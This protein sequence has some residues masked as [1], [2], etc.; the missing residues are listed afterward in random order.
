MSSCRK[1]KFFFFVAGSF[2]GVGFFRQKGSFR[3]KHREDRQKSDEECDRERKLPSGESWSV[4]DADR[5]S[6]SY[7]TG[8]ARRPIEVHR[9]HRESIRRISSRE[10]SSPF[11]RSPVENLLTFTSPVLVSGTKKPIPISLSGRNRTEIRFSS[12]KFETFL[13]FSWQNRTLKVVI[14]IFVL[15]MNWTEISLDFS[16]SKIPSWFFFQFATKNS[17]L[18]SKNVLVKYFLSEPFDNFCFRFKI[19]SLVFSSNFFTFNSINFKLFRVSTSNSQ[20]FLSLTKFESARRFSSRARRFDRFSFDSS[21]FR[22]IQN[23]FQINIPSLRSFFLFLQRGKIGIL[24][25]K[26]HSTIKRDRNNST[27]KDNG[28]I[29][30]QRVMTTVDTN[31]SNQSWILSMSSC[32]YFHSNLMNYFI[33]YCRFSFHVCQM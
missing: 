29:R 10:N 31:C 11:R 5:R 7:R 23:L 21:R 13:F 24:Q 14:S 1:V 26:F 4:D 33:C 18:W 28:I 27:R 2:D 22:S 30:G 6:T 19:Y 17:F 16:S 12:R 32:S 8:R 3:R 20:H 9:S 25:E 15:S